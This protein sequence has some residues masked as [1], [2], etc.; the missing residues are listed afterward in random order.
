MIIQGAGFGDCTG[1]QHRGYTYG[2]G[3]H[4]WATYTA[5][6][7]SAHGVAIWYTAMGFATGRGKLP[8]SIEL[9]ESDFAPMVDYDTLPAQ[10]VSEIPLAAFQGRGDKF[11]AGTSYVWW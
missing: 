4:V 11:S 7:T 9:F 3:G 2:C 10:T 8:Q 5:V 1:S 6:P